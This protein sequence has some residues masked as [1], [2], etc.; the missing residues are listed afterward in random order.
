MYRF[1]CDCKG[2]SCDTPST[3]ADVD[4]DDLSLEDNGNDKEE[5]HAEFCLWQGYNPNPHEKGCVLTIFD[6]DDCL[7]PTWCVSEMAYREALGFDVT[8]SH[9]HSLERHSEVLAD[10]LRVART[11]GPVAIVTLSGASWIRMCEEAYL[12]GFI[13]SELLDE[14]DISIHYS[15]DHLSCITN[16]QDSKEFVSC[17][18]KSMTALLK[19]ECQEKGLPASVLCVGD[20]DHEI[21][22]IKEVFQCDEERNSP[23]KTVKH[24]PLCKTVKF[25]QHPSF[26][27]LDRELCTLKAQMP[28]MASFNKDFDLTFGD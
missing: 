17:K 3:N 25:V 7:F 6:W 27:V 9:F 24:V 28:N 4:W 13:L 14:L 23:H 15:R 10:T 5:L 2:M 11:F 8:E 18:A 21:L 22:A 26:E 20:S 19:Q 12:Y 1:D 16:D